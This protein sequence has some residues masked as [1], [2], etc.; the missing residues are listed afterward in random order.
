LRPS[1][2]Q[3]RYPEEERRNR[4]RLV[5]SRDAANGSLLIHQDARIYLAS[6]TDTTRLMHELTEGRYAWL[7]VLR[8]AVALNGQKLQ[9]SDGAAVSDEKLL[10]VEAAGDAEVMLFDLA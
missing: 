9:T 2:E 3:K 6:L 5:A 8:G 4:F 7:Q 10:S 1:Y